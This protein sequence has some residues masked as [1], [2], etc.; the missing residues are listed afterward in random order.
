MRVTT[1]LKMKPLL[2]SRNPVSMSIC[3]RGYGVAPLPEQFV[4]EAS[5]F[6][7]RTSAMR[8]RRK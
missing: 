4:R 7:P 6:S 2:L 8:G 1:V 3:S 5:H